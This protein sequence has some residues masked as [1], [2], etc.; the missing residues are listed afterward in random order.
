MKEAEM[1]AQSI[2]II[3]D[4]IPGQE[5]LSCSNTLSSDTRESIFLHPAKCFA[6]VGASR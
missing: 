5:R 1:I 2:F 6:E 3:S 4:F